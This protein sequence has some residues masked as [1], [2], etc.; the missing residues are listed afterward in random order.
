VPVKRLV[1]GRLN[2]C[3]LVIHIPHQWCL[4]RPLFFRTSGEPLNHG[5]TQS[6]NAGLVAVDDGYGRLDAGTKGPGEI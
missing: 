2:F 6:M 4:R 5:S 3:A 1:A